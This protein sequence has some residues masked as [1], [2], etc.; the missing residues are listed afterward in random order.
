[1]P[2]CGR[3]LKSSTTRVLLLFDLGGG[4]LERS[5]IVWG[6]EYPYVA[7]PLDYCPERVC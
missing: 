2:R 1:M 6:K 4:D 7:G 5:V 3:L